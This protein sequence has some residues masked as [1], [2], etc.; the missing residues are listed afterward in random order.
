MR[1]G[2]AE[3][4]GDAAVVLG[5]MVGSDWYRIADEAAGTVRNPRSRP[6]GVVRARL[7]AF[8]DAGVSL[9]LLGSKG[10]VMEGSA[11]APEE[12]VGE[13]LFFWAERRPRRDLA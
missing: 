5:V 8:P 11:S 4:N 12:L 2:A 9:A 1:N 3:A 10:A 6:V 13:S 7:E